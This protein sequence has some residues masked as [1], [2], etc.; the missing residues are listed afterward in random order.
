MGEGKGMECPHVLQ[1]DHCEPYSH[2]AECACQADKAIFLGQ[3]LQD[4]GVGMNVQGGSEA[5]IP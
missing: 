3:L 4:S 5:K 2:G 1:L